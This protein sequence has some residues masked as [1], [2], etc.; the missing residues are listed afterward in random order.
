MY[1]SSLEHQKADWIGIHEK[2]CD[3]LAF[4]RQPAPFLASRE[5][6]ERRE[7][8]VQLKKVCDTTLYTYSGISLSNIV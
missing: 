8:E 1:F 7:K 2:I 4:L 3:K 6:R 5:D